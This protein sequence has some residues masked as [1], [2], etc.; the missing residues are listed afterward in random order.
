MSTLT[1]LVIIVAGAAVAYLLE[2]WSERSHA[3]IFTPQNW[4]GP[5]PE[6][7]W[8]HTAP[9]RHMD[10]LMGVV[11]AVFLSLFA[12]GSIMPK[13]TTLSVYY[14]IMYTF[15]ASAWQIEVHFPESA[16]AAVFDGTT[17]DNAFLK[18]TDTV[19]G[20][21]VGVLFFVV[22]SGLG[23]LKTLPALATGPL[24]PSLIILGFAIP[25]CEEAFFRGFILPTITED[26]GI[27]VGLVL[28][29]LFFGIFHYV[30]PGGSL[31]FSAFAF[32]FGL[33]VGILA[34]RD[35]T[36][37]TPFVAHAVFNVLAIL[38]ASGFL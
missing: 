13:Y 10:A 38:V 30:V 9:K 36:M 14:L 18:P 21:V 33:A 12:I 32:F 7:S 11:V 20:A 1:I 35:K 15:H 22:G 26:A 19:K 34:L 8:T 28:S 27:C 2:E 3:K 17:K 24:V 25:S 37:Y 29:S 5:A 16:W 23:L 31:A 6:G 4:F